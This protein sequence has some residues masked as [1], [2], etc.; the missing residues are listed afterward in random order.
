[1]SCFSFFAADVAF[2][3][4][5]MKVGE[6]SKDNSGLLEGARGNEQPLG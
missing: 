6:S 5:G 4:M 3:K 1:M 2:L